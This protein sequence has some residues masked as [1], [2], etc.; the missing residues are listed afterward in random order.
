MSTE[1]TF[2]ITV[3]FSLA[4]AVPVGIKPLLKRAGIID[5]PNERS[6]H[7]I[8]AVRGGGL[9][10]FTAIAL[11]LAYAAISSSASNRNLLFVVLATCI[12]A[13]VLGWIEDSSGVRIIVRAGS[14]F[15]IGTAATGA[16]AI[17]TNH[18]LWWA[19]LGGAVS[20]GLINVVNFMDGVNGISSLHGL[21]AGSTFVAIG[22][23]NETSW[24]V[25]AG[26]ILAAAY[27][28]FLP[29]NIWGGMFLG[30]VGS[31]LLGGVIAAI[32]TLGWMQRLPIIALAAPMSIYLA[33]TSLTL[34]SR[35]LAHERLYEAHRDHTY[36]R[37]NKAGFSHLQVATIAA[38][39][40]VLTAIVGIFSSTTTG[41]MRPALYA[42][43]VAAIGAY[44][45]LRFGFK[46]YAELEFHKELE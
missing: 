5:V 21:I 17:T 20:I 35:T 34:I 14:Q 33:D 37:L 11:A 19:I 41:P 36:Q 24:I 6:S 7:Q 3:A 38:A 25:F 2:A 32:I 44:S 9:A 31:Y 4:L 40:S 43:L 12:A 16:A 46:K 8:P 30:D 28:A 26:G 23:L 18:S 15:L 13:A 42:L 10:Q 1:Q 39:F 29:W 27:I 22:L 45:S